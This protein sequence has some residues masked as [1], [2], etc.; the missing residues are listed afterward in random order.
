MS[1]RSRVAPSL[2]EP[3]LAWVTAHGV[4]A[5]DLVELAL[6]A[7]KRVCDGS[8]LREPWDEA[9]NPACLAAVRDLRYGL[10]DVLAT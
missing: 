6:R 8:A 7:T 1:G 4:P 3:A 9:A 2:P 5:D 10:G